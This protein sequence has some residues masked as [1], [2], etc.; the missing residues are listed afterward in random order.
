MTLHCAQV[1]VLMS[2]VLGTTGFTHNAARL[3]ER[4]ENDIDLSRAYNNIELLQW[5]LLY[6]GKLGFPATNRC[7]NSL[8]STRYMIYTVAVL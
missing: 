2:C 8:A 6:T 4:V 1:Y 7:E 5:F 3:I